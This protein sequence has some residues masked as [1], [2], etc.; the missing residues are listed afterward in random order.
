MNIK[1]NNKIQKIVTSSRVGINMSYELIISNS[2]SLSSLEPFS[3]YLFL[4][5]L[6]SISILSRSCLFGLLQLKLR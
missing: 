6:F 4:G 1:S 2:Y 5:I 3:P